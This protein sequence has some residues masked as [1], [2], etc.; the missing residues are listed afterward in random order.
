MTDAQITEQMRNE[1][2]ELLK[3]TP[4][5][6]RIDTINKARA[7]KRM[8]EAATKAIKGKNVQTIQSIRAELSPFYGS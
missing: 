6:D 1:I 8:H 7:F 5:A 2:R 3:R 4:R